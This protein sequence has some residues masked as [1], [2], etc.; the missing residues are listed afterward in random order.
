[1][2]MFYDCV[3]LVWSHSFD[4][5]IERVV[6]G[7]EGRRGRKKGGRERERV[8]GREGEGEKGKKNMRWT[9]REEE[10]YWGTVREIDREGRG[11]RERGRKMEREKKEGMEEE[12][13]DR[14][15]HTHTHMQNKVF[16]F[17]KSFHFIILLM[18]HVTHVTANRWHTCQWAKDVFTHDASDQVWQ[19]YCK[20]IGHPRRHTQ[21]GWL[22]INYVSCLHST[23]SKQCHFPL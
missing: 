11:G 23:I 4:E 17:H 8:V 13:T 22:N 5:F 2:E 20:L 14:Q 12:E 15:T 1:M 9:R 16:R 7:R 10:M 21:T 18:P 3:I 6:G 19:N